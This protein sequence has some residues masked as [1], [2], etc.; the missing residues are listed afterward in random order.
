M[1]AVSVRCPTELDSEKYLL[2]GGGWWVDLT[3]QACVSRPRCRGSDAGQAPNPKM[4]DLPKR[5]S[6]AAT[7]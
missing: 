1:T 2:K 4:C 7:S 3:R 6:L 5:I